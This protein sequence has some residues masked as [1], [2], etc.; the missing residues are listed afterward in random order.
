[1]SPKSCYIQ[2]PDGRHTPRVTMRSCIRNL[3]THLIL[4]TADNLMKEYHLMTSTRQR[5]SNSIYPLSSYYTCF[6]IYPPDYCTEQNW[7]HDLG[8]LVS[9]MDQDQ[10]SV[11]QCHFTF[12]FERRQ[13]KCVGI[14][15][16]ASE[17]PCWGAS[18]ND[19]QELF[20]V[21][22]SH[23]KFTVLFPE[24]ST[25]TTSESCGIFLEC[26]KSESRLN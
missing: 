21:R 23:L 17:M 3:Q 2:R 12:E 22:I 6:T 25:A 7:Q 15:W 5:C 1:M 18:S 20:S 24:D 19:L 11:F 26:N 16:R 13:G 4:N 10:C 14:N 9:T 8:R